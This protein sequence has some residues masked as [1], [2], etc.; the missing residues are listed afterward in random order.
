MGPNVKISAIVSLAFIAGLAWAVNRV[1]PGE[2][3]VEAAPLTTVSVGRGGA[4]NDFGAGGERQPGFARASAVTPPARE[5][6]PRVEPA[7]PRLERPILPPISSISDVRGEPVVAGATRGSQA[8]G[9]AAPRVLA[10]LVETPEDAAATAKL[11]PSPAGVDAAPLPPTPKHY[12]VQ[13]GDF[14]RRIAKQM[15]KS[16]DERYVAALL[17]ANPALRKRPNRLYAGETLT[18]PVLAEAASPGAPA[19]SPP[20]AKPAARTSSTNK[21]ERPRK[22][23]PEKAVASGAVRRGSTP[24]TAG[25]PRSSKPKRANGPAVIADA[26]GLKPEAAKPASVRPKQRPGQ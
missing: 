18:I 10:A 24:A 5:A 19:S 23:S 21:L 2:R 3:A 14:L 17:S 7:A 26:R 1:A 20:T 8:A 15:W 4:A 12:V 6:T 22:S 16:D 9:D 11:P 25:P 13:R